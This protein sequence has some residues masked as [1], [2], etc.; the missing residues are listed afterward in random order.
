MFDKLTNR[1]IVDTVWKT[2]GFN[3]AKSEKPKRDIILN[4]LW[5][6]MSVGIII[7]YNFGPLF[8]IFWQANGCWAC[9]L[10]V[11]YKVFLHFNLFFHHNCKKQEKVIKKTWKGGSTKCSG[12]TLLDTQALVYSWGKYKFSYECLKLNFFVYF[13]CKIVDCVVLYFFIAVKFWSVASKP[14][15][16]PFSLFMF[17][18]NFSPVYFH[19]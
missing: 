15:L 1:E 3:L 18:C 16:P 5:N 19:L 4:E 13:L 14:W 8:W 10:Q 7:F 2:I 6:L 11:W 9:H 12:A 17:F